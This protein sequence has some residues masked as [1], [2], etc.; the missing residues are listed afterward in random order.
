MDCSG[1]HFLTTHSALT[2]EQ[3][4]GSDASK[5]RSPKRLEQRDAFFVRAD[6]IP[7]TGR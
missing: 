3:F 2:A 5:G 1:E 6:R 4:S 7:A